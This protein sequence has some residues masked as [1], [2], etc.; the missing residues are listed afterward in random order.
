MKFYYDGI[1]YPCKWKTKM[2][3]NMW[4]SQEPAKLKVTLPISVYDKIKK[5][6][7]ADNTNETLFDVI[8]FKVL[9]GEGE[10]LN[11]NKSKDSVK[12]M[13]QLECY[14]KSFVICSQFK[15][16][17]ILIVNFD[18]SVIE[19]ELLKKSEMRDIILSEFI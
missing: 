6:I 12:E 16:E 2:S 13:W 4:Y 17:K 11:F 19:S 3:K 7:K 15:K 14:L 9:K 18:I 10:I 5:D 8:K 1:G